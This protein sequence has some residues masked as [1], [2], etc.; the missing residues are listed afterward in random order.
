MPRH[1]SLL[2]SPTIALR[3]ST[4]RLAAENEGVCSLWHHNPHTILT[5]WID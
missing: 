4:D 3:Y 1:F 2:T 5:Y